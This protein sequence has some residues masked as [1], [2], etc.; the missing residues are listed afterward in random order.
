MTPIK[1][2]A[3]FAAIGVAF[4]PTGVRLATVSNQVS[5]WADIRPSLCMHDPSSNVLRVLVLVEPCLRFFLVDVPKIYEDSVVYDGTGIQTTGT[6]CA[7]SHMN[8]AKQC[9]VCPV[10]FFSVHQSLMQLYVDSDWSPVVYRSRL[11]STRT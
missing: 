6:S 9:Q 5:T 3:I 10:F 11:H 2:I 7:I 8:Q 1:V 4:I